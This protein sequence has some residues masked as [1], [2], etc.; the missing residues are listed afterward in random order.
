MSGARD[1]N[2]WVVFARVLKLWDQDP[3]GFDDDYLIVLQSRAYAALTTTWSRHCPS[4]P[5]GTAARF[6]AAVGA[7]RRTAVELGSARRAATSRQYTADAAARQRRL[8]EATA[9]LRELLAPARGGAGAGRAAGAVHVRLRGR[10]GDPGSG[11]F[12]LGHDA[13]ELPWQVL[14]VICQG[15]NP[16]DRRPPGRAPPP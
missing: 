4:P 12:S 7:Y 1:L 6:E 14:S 10:G 16:R 9:E 3:D 13:H 15:A 2:S 5:R 8:A 11:A